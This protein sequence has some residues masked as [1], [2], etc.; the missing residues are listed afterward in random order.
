VFIDVEAFWR[1]V[2]VGA[3]IIVAV[4]VDRSQRPIRGGKD[5]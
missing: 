3:M 5:E 4:L 1:F 2:E